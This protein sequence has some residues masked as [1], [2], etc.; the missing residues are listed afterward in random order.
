MISLMVGGEQSNRQWRM[1]IIENSVRLLLKWLKSIILTKLGIANLLVKW[2]LQMES[3][4]SLED[5]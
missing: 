5:W 3:S 1:T 4:A 2:A